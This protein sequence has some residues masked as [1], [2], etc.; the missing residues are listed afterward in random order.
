MI[1]FPQLAAFTLPRENECMTISV[2]EGKGIICIRVSVDVKKNYA[3]GK[4]S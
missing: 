2:K 1:G 3:K 4:K